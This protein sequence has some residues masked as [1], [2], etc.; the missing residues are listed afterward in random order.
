MTK[1]ERREK[2]RNDCLKRDKNKCCFC[3]ESENL[4]VHH[5]QDRH[6]FKNGGYVK[7]NGISLCKTHHLD[8]ELY[9]MTTGSKFN[10]GMHPDDLY[11]IINSSF[12]LAKEKDSYNI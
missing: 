8:A 10:E 12:D 7:E 9:H 4:D 1:K 3:N 2:F 11:L 5:I 6:L